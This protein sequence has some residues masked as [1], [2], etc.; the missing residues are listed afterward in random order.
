MSKRQLCLLPERAD[1]AR[2][3][4]HRAQPLACKG[5]QFGKALRAQVGHLV[6]LQMAPDV[7]GGVE[8]GRVGGKEL[9]VN[10]PFERFDVLAH[11]PALVHPQPV[12]DD[13]QLAPDLCLERFEEFHDL[14]P[15]DGPGEQAKVEEKET[16][17]KEAKADADKTRKA[18]KNIQGKFEKATLGDLGGLAEL[19]QKLQQEEQ[20]GGEA[21]KE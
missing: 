16:A 9:D 6:L 17:K 14:R 5:R 11:Q 2:T 18:V 21:G 1:Q 15:L 13:E 7:F 10:S 8:L 19:K 4:L 20:N 3:P 12:P